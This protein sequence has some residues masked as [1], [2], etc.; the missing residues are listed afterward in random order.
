M[1]FRS[2]R[3]AVQ[4]ALYYPPLFD[5]KSR[6]DGR[7]LSPSHELYGQGK[8]T[9]AIESLNAIPEAE[10]NGDY[11]S[12]R[13]G[14]LLLVG[15]ADEAEPDIETALRENQNNT[16]ALSLKAI[17]AIVRN[18]KTKALELAN[19]AVSID[20]KSAAARIALSYALQANFQIEE[21]LNA[22]RQATERDQTNAL[23][24]ARVAEL[25]LSIPN[26]DKSKEAAEK[27]VQLN[28]N[29]ARTQSILGFANL[30]RIDIKAAKECFNRAIALDQA[31][32]L[33]RLGLGLATIREGKLNE[34]REQIEIAGSLDPEN[35]LIRSYLGKAYYEEK[36]DKQAGRQFDL[37]KERDP[38]D[39]TPYFYDAIRKQ[40]E[41]RPIEALREV[42]RSIQLN[43]SRGVYRSRLLLDQDSAARGVN[44]ATLYTELGFQ[45]L[46]L[47]EAIQSVASSPGSSAAHLFMA[48]SYSTL[49]RHSIAKASEILQSQLHQPLS[50][51]SI[52]QRTEEKLFSPSLNL[53]GTNGAGATTTGLSEFSQLYSGDGLR[54]QLAAIGGNKG[55]RLEQLGLSL[56]KGNVAANISRL[57]LET[58]GFT[59]GND[60]DRDILN[61]FLQAS[62]T[63]RTD[64]QFEFRN[65]ET[66]RGDVLT[67]FEPSSALPL[68]N[69]Q[70]IRS[71]RLGAKHQISSSSDA[72]VSIAGEKIDAQDEVFDI[73]TNLRGQA[74]SVELQTLV[75]Q[76]NLDVVLGAG[77]FQGEQELPE[78]P[79]FS[80]ASQSQTNF[81]GYGHFNLVPGSLNLTLGLSA[82]FP[83]EAGFNRAPL[84]PKLGVFWHPTPTTLV[85]AAAFRT[86]KRR[87]VSDQTIEPTQIGG[88]NQFFD[89]FEGTVSKRY[90]LGVDHKFAAKIFYGFEGSIRDLSIP[91]RRFVDAGFENIAWNEKL[92][93]AYLFWLPSDF[94][95]ASVEYRSEVFTRP[96]IFTGLEGF[97]DVR[98]QR[99]PVALGLFFRNRL[100]VRLIQ[101]Y[102]QERAKL[103]VAIGF[104]E[105]DL[106][107]AFWTTDL[108]ISY[109]LPRR[110][111]YIAFEAKN[112]LDKQFSFQDSDP[113]NPTV[114]ARRLLLGKLYLTF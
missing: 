2:P 67:N 88:F 24:W 47:A 21:A 37:A 20:D 84:S 62:F 87:L 64:V 110:L 53:P 40:A 31:D 3:D 32:P 10:R 39:P 91:V 73:K 113:L 38:K 51:N 48:E 5:P 34:G 82:D 35:S 58:Q 22:A 83:D 26:Y 78:A 43:D 19:Q 14:L 15:R 11:Y 9:D 86:L 71:L 56:L 36:R 16:D 85:R 55:T 98:I 108:A 112:L 89:D 68:R 27:A 97:R 76:K 54:L 66:D 18:D 41:N 13:A 4:W 50:L 107:E 25:E 80:N 8:I 69:R 95:A 90:G 12:Y 44:Q 46:G 100:S 79:L 49:P 75:R 17:I 96:E 1:L 106:R 105:V 42:E 52:P 102:F 29:L 63:P 33:P 114:S 61:V 23:A 101:T 60:L 111:G 92:Y 104:P 6:S 77:S 103:L 57:H 74:Y 72:I 7:N 93:R 65:A 99:I 70:R 45:Q 59:Q 28:P 109:R 30:T 81:Y 94:V